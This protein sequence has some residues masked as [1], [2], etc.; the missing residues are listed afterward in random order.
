[1]ERSGEKGREKEKRGRSGEMWR[2]IRGRGGENWREVGR[3][4]GRRAKFTKK[5]ER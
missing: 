3:T 2:Y 4:E 5:G 1:M